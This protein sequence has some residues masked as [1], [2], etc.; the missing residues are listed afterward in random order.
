MQIQDAWSSLPKVPNLKEADAIFLMEN[1][2]EYSDIECIDEI[3]NKLGDLKW[4]KEDS[5]DVDVLVG[6]ILKEA[7]MY[8]FVYLYDSVLVA[9]WK[10]TFRE[11]SLIYLKDFVK[12]RNDIKEAKEKKARNEWEKKRESRWYH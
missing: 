5:K 4:K 10:N 9:K 6:D 11:E 1:E 7:E 2:V 8:F 3:R 12:G